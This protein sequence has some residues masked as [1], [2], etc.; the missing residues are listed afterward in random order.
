M[1]S[2]DRFGVAALSLCES[3]I[4][5]LKE[6]GVLDE[7]EIQGLL[8]DVCSAH[9]NAAAEGDDPELHESVADIADEIMNGGNSV[10]LL[11]KPGRNAAGRI[12]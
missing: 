5:A 10:R 6:R 8:E 9:R 12:P 11:R 4:L 2:P 1:A 3:L 7:A